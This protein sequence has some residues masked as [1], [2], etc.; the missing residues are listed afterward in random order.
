MHT[1]SAI[2]HFK[3]ALNYCSSRELQGV[4]KGGKFCTFRSL[5]ITNRMTMAANS[6]ISFFRFHFF[7]ASAKNRFSMRNVRQSAVNRK[8]PLISENAPD[9]QHRS[10]E[11]NGKSKLNKQGI[12]SEDWQSCV[13]GLFGG[14]YERW[15]FSFRLVLYRNHNSYITIF[16]SHFYAT[17]LWNSFFLVS[18]LHFLSALSPRDL[19]SLRDAKAKEN[20]RAKVAVIKQISRRGWRWKVFLCNAVEQNKF[21]ARILK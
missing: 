4:V 11:R 16:W 12:K 14:I 13:L 1:R 20:C 7:S 21:A 18:C 8:Y 5:K 3:S 6:I 19:F 2:T 10:I 9:R 15:F 17:S